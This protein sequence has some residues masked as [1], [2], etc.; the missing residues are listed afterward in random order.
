MSV[1]TFVC[2]SS[3]EIIYKKNSDQQTCGGTANYNNTYF[4]NPN[5]PGSWGGGSTC[6]IV[7]SPASADICQIR[8]DFLDLS[9]APPNGDGV[10]NRDAISVAGGSS[11]VPTLCGMNSGQHVYVNFDGTQPITINI[12]A[13]SSYTF[14]RKWHMM[15]N[16]IDCNSAKLAPSGCLQYYSAPSGVIRSFNYGS[17]ANSAL[18]SVGVDGTRQIANLNYGICIATAA[19]QCSI[20]YS[21]LSSDTYSFTVT[22]DVGAVDPALLGTSALQDQSCSTDYI[23]IPS[24]R[25]N[26]AALTSDRFCGLGLASTTSFLKKGNASPFVVYVV[27]DGNEQMDIGNRGFSLSYSQNE[28]PVNIA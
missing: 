21:T 6:S 28:C 2:L 13:S 5:Y 16:Q 24:P 23:V 12:A 20:T 3:K 27:T 14:G 22:G 10:C 15:I 7:V 9:L 26:N 11:Y 18:N 19:D 25:Q 17:G 4:V 8:L 1:A